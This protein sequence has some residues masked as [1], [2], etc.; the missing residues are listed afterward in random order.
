MAPSRRV[1]LG[2]M[3][4]SLLIIAGILVLKSSLGSEPNI[5][6]IHVINLDKDTK[7]WNS[8]KRAAAKVQPPI[9][10]FSAVNGKLVQINDLHQLGIGIAM[11]MKGTGDY[12]E[13]SYSL[14]NIGTVGCFLSHRNLLTM[15]SKMNYGANDGHLILEDDINLPDDFLSS[16]DRWHTIKKE[17]PYNWDMVYLGINSPIGDLISPNV[18][19]LRDPIKNKGNWGTHAYVVKHSSL[20]KILSWLAFM[21]DAIDGQY[22]MK[23]DSWNVYCAMPFVINLDPVLS[24]DSSITKM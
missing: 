19:K 2:F 11:M 17:V 24:A 15:L 22:N 20:P 13:Q 12:V 7:R 14:R 4:M 5:K 18:M 3:L 1:F 9:Q 8:I 21:I 6:T 10:R 16:S 23:F